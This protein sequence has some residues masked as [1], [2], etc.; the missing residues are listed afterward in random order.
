MTGFEPRTSG[1]GSDRS[2]NCATTTS[3]GTWILNWHY[4]RREFA[5]DKK[6]NLSI[7]FVA[8]TNKAVKIFI[9]VWGSPG[10]VVIRG[11]WRFK[12]YE[13]E[14]W[15]HLFIVKFVLV[16]EK[17]DNKLKRPGMAHI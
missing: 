4:K 3:L 2:T 8:L 7:I 17:T 10:Q 1:V 5:K 13:F 11:D 12:G 14:S 16:F 9:N 15:H 6:K